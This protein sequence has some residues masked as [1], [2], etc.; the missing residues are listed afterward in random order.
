MN[1]LVE[2]SFKREICRF[3]ADVHQ[4]DNFIYGQARAFTEGVI[5]FQSLAN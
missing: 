3:K 2:F 1:W 4:I 5:L